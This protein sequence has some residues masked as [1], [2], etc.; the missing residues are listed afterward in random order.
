MGI[1]GT[2]TC[3]HCGYSAEWVTADFDCGFSGDVVTPVVCAEHGIRGARTGLK[4]WD[5]GWR[6]ATRESYPCPECRAESPRWDRRT[7]PACGRRGAEN[8]GWAPGIMW[9]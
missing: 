9:D 3:P 6:E 4:A 1:A 7:C 8:E 5:D 2:Y